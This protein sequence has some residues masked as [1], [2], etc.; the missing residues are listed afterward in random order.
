MSEREKKVELIQQRMIK[1]LGESKGDGIRISEDDG[2]HIVF[3][4]D[5]IRTIIRKTD[6]ILKCKK[7]FLFFRRLILAGDRMD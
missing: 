7:L 4:L 1:K 2:V 6:E 3:M 5:I